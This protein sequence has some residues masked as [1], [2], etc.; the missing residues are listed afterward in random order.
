MVPEF[1]NLVIIN[2]IPGGFRGAMVVYC[3]LLAIGYG[4]QKLIDRLIRDERVRNVVCII[5]FGILGL[6]LEW[7]VIGNSPWQ[8]PDAIQW[9]MF[10]YW[11]GLFMVPRILTDGREVV[12]SLRRTIQITYVIYSAVHL[13]LALILPVAVLP[14][15]IPILWTVVY[16]AFGGFYVKY[17]RLLASREQITETA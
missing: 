14:F 5:L 12:R 4:I 3:V 8:N 16:T 13:A 9:G 11:A 2:Q 17:I 10:V 1:T 7:F 15:W 6:A